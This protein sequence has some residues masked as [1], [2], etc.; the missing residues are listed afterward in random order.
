MG[1]L[2]TTGPSAQEAPVATKIKI[3]AAS[4]FL[5]VTA[6]GTINLSTS[7]QLLVDIAKTEQPPADYD[8]LV[9][10]R[11]AHSELSTLD[12]YQLAKQLFEH[13][14]TFRRKVALLVR[15]GLGFDRASFFETCSRNRGFSVNAFTD[16][17]TALRWLLSAEDAPEA[18]TASTGTRAGDLA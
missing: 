15:A 18:E 8:L 6:D 4:D 5:E 1:Q 9:D 14:D 13:G 7:Q 11:H 3:I 2:H 12:V 17:E 16:Y 10:F